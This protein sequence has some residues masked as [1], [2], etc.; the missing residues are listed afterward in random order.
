MAEVKVGV[1]SRDATEIENI[2][3]IAP[4][5]DIIL[6][7]G[8]KVPA[9]GG[10]MQLTDDAN[11]TITLTDTAKI[12]VSSND[13]TR[14]FLGQK[15][16]AGSHI[17]VTELNDGGDED[18]S[19]ATDG[20]ASIGGTLT[21]GTVGSILFVGSGPVIAEDNANLFFDNTNNRQG[22]RTSTPLSAFQVNG[23]FAVHATTTISVTGPTAL[24]ETHY[25]V[26]VNCSSN[27]VSLD[28]PS[29]VNCPGRIYTV[30]VIAQSGAFTCGIFTFGVQT[31]D[32]ALSYTLRHVQET[33]VIQSDGSNWHIVD[34]YTAER[35]RVS[36]NDTTP[37][38]L[39]GK[40]VE[41]TAI[42]LVEV[43]DGTNETLRVDLDI[44]E[45]T[46]ETTLDGANDYLIMYDT[47]AT[48]HRKILLNTLVNNV[49][50]GRTYAHNGTLIDIDSNE[51]NQMRFGDGNVT[52]GVRV[53]NNGEL[54]GFSGV[55]ELARTAG[56]LT[57]RM[58]INGVQQS[59]AGQTFTIDGTNTL[60]NHI[61]FA[62]P[63]QFNAGDIITMVAQSDA[64]FAPSNNDATIA[65]FYR[66]R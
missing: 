30:K 9:S 17:T 57:F 10:D 15:I 64:T 13:T 49:S 59:G 24:G 61:V 23:S 46:A 44:N 18:L 58:V 37:G 19:I 36:S 39:N 54:L 27:S 50:N 3:E 52:A 63:I 7:R 20:G 40:L 56:T 33:L 4:S 14:G 25:L 55:L 29:T 45:L 42:D 8:L 26:Q 41:G 11:G 6:G 21:S 16:V 35:V 1:L 22:I 43:G 47:S 2:E 5:S 65:F 34:H 60:S 51:T 62:T 31:L 53:I 28:L 32:G 66:D 12:K 48:A 38:F